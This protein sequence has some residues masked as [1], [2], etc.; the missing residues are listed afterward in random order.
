MDN[1]T[2]WEDNDELITIKKGILY[3]FILNEHKLAVEEYKKSL[4][5]KE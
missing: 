4:S 2:T 1:T 3:K 5:D